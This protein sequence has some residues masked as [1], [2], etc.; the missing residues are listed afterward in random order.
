MRWMNLEPMI[1]NELSQKEKNKYHILMHIYGIYKD[2]TDEFI[3]R[4]ALEKQIYGHVLREG[5]GEMY[6]ES[7]LEI[8]ISMCEIYSQWE[9]AV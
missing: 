3:Y 7:N 4:A 5:V 8:Y 1:Q 2:G 6:G 9:F